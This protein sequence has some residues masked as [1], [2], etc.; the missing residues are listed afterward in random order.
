MPIGGFDASDPGPTLEQS[1]SR[2]E[3]NVTAMTV[4]GT[5]LYDLT[6]GASSG[7]NA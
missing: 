2:V 6:A 4:G 7:S 5:T 1:Q 3:A